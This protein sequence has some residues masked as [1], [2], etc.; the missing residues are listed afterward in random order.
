MFMLWYFWPLYWEQRILVADKSAYYLGQ[1]YLLDLCIKMQLQQEE[2]EK[3]KRREI[4]REIHKV[5]EQKRAR[6]NYYGFPSSSN[7]DSKQ[8][9]H[10]LESLQQWEQYFLQQ[11]QQALEVH[12]M[13]EQRR[14]QLV[15]LLGIEQTWMEQHGIVPPVQAASLSTIQEPRRLHGG[16]IR[17]LERVCASISVKP[18]IT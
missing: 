17:R 3:Q 6:E 18:G 15:A 5:Q 4:T 11:E 8:L 13:V 2:Q 10:K 1:G 12:P 14:E 7:E 16:Q 9:D